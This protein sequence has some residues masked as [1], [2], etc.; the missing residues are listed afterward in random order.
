M[1][2]P[3]LYWERAVQTDTGRQ[4]GR[5]ALD[6]TSF[7]SSRCMPRGCVLFLLSFPVLFSF[8]LEMAVPKETSE[9]L[10]AALGSILPNILRFW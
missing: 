6:F 2:L 9:G 4:V 1:L 10:L 3:C 8:P 7:V 5:V